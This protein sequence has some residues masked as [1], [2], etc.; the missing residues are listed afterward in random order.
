MLFYVKVYV[1]TPDCAIVT[2]SKLCIYSYSTFLPLQLE[3]TLSR[4]SR[5]PHCRCPGALITTTTLMWSS[6]LT[7]QCATKWTLCGPVGDMLQKTHSCQV[8]RSAWHDIVTVFY[9]G[10]CLSTYMNFYAIMWEM[11]ASC[12]LLRE[13][14]TTCGY[15]VANSLLVQWL[16]GVMIGWLL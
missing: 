3:Q 4:W 9:T 6:S 16:C 13:S 8:K 1:P 12:K 7:W 14:P 11:L 5:S 2:F 15:P 10:V